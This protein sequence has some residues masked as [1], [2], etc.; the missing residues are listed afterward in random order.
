MIGVLYEP[1]PT[2]HQS[3]SLG[4]L[5]DNYLHAHGYT[6]PAIDFIVST[7]KSSASVE[8]FIDVLT[9]HGFA[10]MEAKFLWDLINIESE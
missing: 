7:V 10:R 5:A 6:L 1:M 9:M 2:S 4:V 3:A 8:E